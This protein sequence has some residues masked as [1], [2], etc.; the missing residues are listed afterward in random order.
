MNI[1]IK[2]EDLKTDIEDAILGMH[3]EIEKQTKIVYEKI[4]DIANKI[5]KEHLELSFLISCGVIF[6]V[7]M[8]MLLKNMNMLR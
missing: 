3:I 4:A 1:F 5:N 8:K 2:T 7:L 6:C